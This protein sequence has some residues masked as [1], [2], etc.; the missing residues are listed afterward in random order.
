[1]PSAQRSTVNLLGQ[2]ELSFDINL[3]ILT[4]YSPACSRLLS[5]YKTMLKLVSDDVPSVE[6]FMKKYKAWQASFQSLAWS[7]GP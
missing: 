3:D 7:Y 1:M 6:Q 4:R 2:S 5:Q